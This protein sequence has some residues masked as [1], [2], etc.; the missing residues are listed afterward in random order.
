MVVCVDVGNTNIVFGAYKEDVLLFTSRIQTELGKTADQYAIAFS[1][2]LQ[3]YHCADVPCEGAII[4]SVVPPLQTTLKTAL[5]RLLGCRVLVVG[6]GVKTGLNI[7]IDNPAST[8]ADLV[9][10][11]VA[12]LKKYP[13]PSIIF[14]LGTATKILALDKFGSFLGGSI[15]PGI[16][17]SL[18]ALSTRTAQLPHIDLDTAQHVI[19]SNTVDCMKSGIVFGTASMMDGMVR[20]YRS[21][22]GADAH[23]VATGGYASAILPFCETQITYDP[24]LVMDG[25]YTIYRKNAGQ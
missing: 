1:A 11:A 22:L 2:I 21:I 23:V 18:N 20:K 25:L 17:I 8:G 7:K 5:S 15:M 12:T 3:L 4:S 6:P 14:D 10:A 13:Q 24:D 19:G 9:C 16:G